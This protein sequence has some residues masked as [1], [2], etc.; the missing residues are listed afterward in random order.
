MFIT[1]TLDRSKSFLFSR[2]FKRIYIYIYICEL[3][4]EKVR[5]VPTH[6]RS[7]SPHV[8]YIYKYIYRE[9]ICES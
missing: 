5:R 6:S 2:L 1:L 4:I 9:Y 8:C 3:S 7:Q